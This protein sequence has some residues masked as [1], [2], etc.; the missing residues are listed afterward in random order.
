MPFT[1]EVE[2]KLFCMR[3]RDIPTSIKSFCWNNEMVEYLLNCLN[4]YK[5]CYRPARY[6]FL[7]KLMM[8][9]YQVNELHPEMLS[10]NVIRK[11]QMHKVNY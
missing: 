3:K 8:Q 10:G 6:S 1:F 7:R 5:A 4:S 9:Q 2:K 11:S